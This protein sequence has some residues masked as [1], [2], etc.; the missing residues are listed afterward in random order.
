[1]VVTCEKCHTRF[2]LDEH[3]LS[4]PKVKARCSRCQNVFWV[5]REEELPDA[6]HLE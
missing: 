3:R 1:M 2:N 5:E 4:G 6:A